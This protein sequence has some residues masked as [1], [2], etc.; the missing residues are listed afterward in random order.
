MPRGDRRNLEP[1]VAVHPSLRTFL[2]R[3]EVHVVRITDL[4]HTVDFLHEMA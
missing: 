3:P 4:M 2:L 1:S